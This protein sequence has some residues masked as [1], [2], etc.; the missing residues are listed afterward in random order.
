[1]LLMVKKGISGAIC[2][3]LHRYAKANN[4]YMKDCDSSTKSSYI[5]YWDVNNPY[6]WEVSQRLPVDDFR[7]KMRSLNYLR[8]LYQTNDDINE[9]YVLE[10]DVS[11][12]KYTQ[13]RHSDL[14]FL[15]E[16]IKIDKF[17]KFFCSI[18]DKKNYVVH[19][20]PQGRPWIMS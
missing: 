10:V 11:Y 16:R 12:P 4:K 13:K 14:L 1:M 15:P 9:R 8:N 6:G 18:H 17:Q 3:A 5:K 7:W 2:H 19:I 20:K